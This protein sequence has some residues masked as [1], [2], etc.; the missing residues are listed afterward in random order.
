MPRLILLHGWGVDAR[1]WRPLAPHWRAD[2]QVA[3]PDWPGYGDRPAL[4]APQDLDALAEA[5]AEALPADAVWVGWS[6][7]GLLAAA[8]CRRL[9]APRGLIMLGMGLRFCHPAAVNDAA[10]N[11]FRRAFARAP[12]ASRREQRIAGAV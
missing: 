2:C 10:L 5:M 3:S 4:S 9:S 6:L 7:G 11:D 1:I 12:E 8:L